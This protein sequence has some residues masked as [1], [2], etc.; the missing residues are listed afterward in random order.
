MGG[1]LYGEEIVIMILKTDTNIS[2]FKQSRRLSHNV[3]E[4]DRQ[5]MFRP[6][7]HPSN[8]ILLQSRGL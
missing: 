3:L 5:T 8:H 4:P 7:R 1:V 2:K 6:Q